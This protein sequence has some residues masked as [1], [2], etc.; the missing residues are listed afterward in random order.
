[1]LTISLLNFNNKQTVMLRVNVFLFR[2]EITSTPTIK[3]KPTSH[4]FVLKGK[5]QLCR[6]ACH[7]W[8]AEHQPEE[9]YLH[10]ETQTQTITLGVRVR[11]SSSAT[12]QSI[13]LMLAFSDS[14]TP[15]TLIL[16]TT[17]N[18]QLV[19]QITIIRWDENHIMKLK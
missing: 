10:L 17:K 2:G 12:N 16:I 9:M 11:S 4:P 8:D 3:L 7:P 14:K 1:M 19:L 5:I 6:L 13:P 18:T 15:Q